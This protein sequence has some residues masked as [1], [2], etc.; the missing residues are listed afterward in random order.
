MTSRRTTHRII[1]AG[2][3]A[4]EAQHKKSKC[5]LNRA[6]TDPPE[7]NVVW[8]QVVCKKFQQLSKR[9][10]VR[11]RMR[12]RVRLRD[13]THT[14]THTQREITWNNTH[15]HTYRWKENV[16]VTMCELY[17]DALAAT[18]SASPRLQFAGKLVTPHCV[19]VCVFRCVCVYCMY[20]FVGDARHAKL[21]TN[22][23]ILNPYEVNKLLW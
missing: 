14:H 8:A 10:R 1:E 5:E 22:F 2:E 9:A 20:L 3:R 12:M 7:V 6:Y 21:I 4:C 23:H 16:V 11:V 13:T 17:I 19:C 15:S 18:A